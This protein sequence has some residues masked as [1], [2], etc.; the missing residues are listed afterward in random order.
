MTKADCELRSFHFPAKRFWLPLR[1]AMDVRKPKRRILGG[2]FAGE[3]V[4][5]GKSAKNFKVGDQVFGS[6]QLRLGAY[7]QYLSL[8]NDYPIGFHT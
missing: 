1:I 4:S 8:P 3:V 2:Y 7:G 6:S 5:F